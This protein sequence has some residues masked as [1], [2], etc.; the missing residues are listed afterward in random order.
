MNVAITLLR[1]EP[2]DKTYASDKS[3]SSRRSVTAT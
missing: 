1:Y 2:K 3:G